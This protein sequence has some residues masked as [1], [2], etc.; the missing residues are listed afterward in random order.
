MISFIKRRKSVYTVSFLILLLISCSGGEEDRFQ[1]TS[2]IEAGFSEAALAELATY[3][4][5]AGSSSLI[6]LHD[7]KIVFEWG[8]IYKKHLIHSIRKSMLN[9]LF[10]IYVERGVIDTSATLAQLKVDDI[11]PLTETEKTARIADLLKSRSGV[12]HP[13]AAE[14]PGMIAKRPER[15]SSPPGEFYYYNNWDFNTLGAIFEQQVG[16]SIY[17][18]FYKEIAIPLGM[19]H[20][21]GEATSLTISDG[22]REF[23]DTDGFYQLEPEKSKYPAYHFRMSAHDMA[24]FGQLYANNGVWKGKQILSEAWIKASSTAYSDTNPYISAGYGLLWNVLKTTETRK[25]VSFYH[26]GGGIHMLGVYPGSKLVFVHRVNT[27]KEFDF[28]QKRLH[29]II[30]MIFNA[31]EK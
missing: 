2:A 31:R 20:F 3:L 26:T 10:G 7:G 1:R 14:A 4:Q 13:A 24:L 22:D 28:P 16:I 23:P 6:I 5:E 12:Y 29:K 11:I 15:G 17:Q 8:D 21:K 30:G 18:A 25:T 27:E 9:S 19:L